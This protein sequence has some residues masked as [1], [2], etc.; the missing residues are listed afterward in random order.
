MDI[1]SM[2]REQLLRVNPEELSRRLTSEEAIHISS[3]LGAFWRYDYE[4]A[5]QGRVGKH[6]IIEFGRHS[7]GFFDSGVLL[8]SL[9]IRYIMA[10]QIV[11]RL[12]E[13]NAPCP[14]WVADVWDRFSGLGE[15]VAR[16]LKTKF[17]IMDQVNGR[18]RLTTAVRFENQLL[19]VGDSFSTGADF[20][21][22]AGA[23]TENQPNAVV[24]P[25]IPVILSRNGARRIV[26]AGAAFQVL[27][28]MEWRIQDFEPGPE[29]C[30]LCAMGSI[31]INPKE[32]AESRLELFT[33]QP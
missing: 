24:L 28:V 25:Y 19:L 30:P 33:S 31:P 17:A 18:P 16:R 8:A 11:M 10:E 7:N 12:N 4:A 21:Q 13:V 20:E 1:K 5:R 14:D 3:T 22:A 27:P 6:A 29:N 15:E 32:S 9:N 23:V 2:N 26:I